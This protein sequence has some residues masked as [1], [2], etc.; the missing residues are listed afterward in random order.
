L[1][2]LWAKAVERAGILDGAAVTA[3]LEKMTNEPTT[4]EPRSF[5]NEIH[6]QNTAEMQIIEIT[7]G[8]PGSDI[9]ST[10]LNKYAT[11]PMIVDQ[12]PVTSAQK[13][14]RIALRTMLESGSS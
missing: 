10:Y 4:F 2:D 7:D 3:E 5:S 13:V 1:I 12:M 6:H 14:D 8:T 11:R 9:E